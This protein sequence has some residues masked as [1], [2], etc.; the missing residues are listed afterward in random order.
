MDKIIEAIPLPPLYYYAA[1]TSVLAPGW[2]RQLDKSQREQ[3]QE[4]HRGACLL[5]DGVRDRQQ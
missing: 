2:K 3:R 5:Q 1:E 4:L